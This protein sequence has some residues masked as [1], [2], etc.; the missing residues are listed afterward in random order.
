VR[1]QH[2]TKRHNTSRRV[3]TCGSLVFGTLG[4][5]RGELR[6]SSPPDTAGHRS[7]ASAVLAAA[8]A[9]LRDLGVR[10]HVSNVSMNVCCRGQSGHD[11][12]GPLLRLLTHNGLWA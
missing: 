4:V 11:A 6:A 5:A 1:P 7:P 9:R 12:A 8:V 2:D 10:K 3:A